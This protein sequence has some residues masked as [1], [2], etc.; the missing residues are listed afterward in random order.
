MRF[1]HALLSIGFV[2]LSACFL[3]PLLGKVSLPLSFFRLCSA[4]WA[5]AMA[6]R[7]CA[8]ASSHCQPAPA[9]SSSATTAAAT[10]PRNSHLL[11]ALLTAGGLPAV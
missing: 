6:L 11:A 3:F 10:I 2:P 8:C 1:E 5:S 9:A 4:L 7:V